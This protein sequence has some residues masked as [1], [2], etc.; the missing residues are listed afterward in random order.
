MVDCVIVTVVYKSHKFDMEIPANTPIET[1][2]PNLIAALQSKG[3][4]PGGSFSLTCNG[5][6]LRPEDTLLQSGVWDGSYLELQNR[7]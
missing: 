5:R 3:I 1:I 6:A 7:Y 4:S 2:K